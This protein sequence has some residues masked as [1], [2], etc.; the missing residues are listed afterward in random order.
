MQ[1]PFFDVLF[2]TDRASR[3]NLPGC[4]GSLERVDVL[5]CTDW[6]GDCCG[7]YY[8][9]LIFDEALRIAGANILE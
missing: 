6:S 7:N 4:A 9:P 1:V 2:F 3:R 8:H 5:F